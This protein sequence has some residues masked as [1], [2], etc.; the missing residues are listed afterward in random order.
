MLTEKVIRI[1]CIHLTLVVA[2]SCWLVSPVK[3]DTVDLAN[4][5][6]LITVDENCHGTINGFAGLN[7]LSCVFAPDPG[8]GGLPSVMTYNL[9]NP[10]GLVAGDVLLSDNGPILDVVRFNPGE[11]GG[12]LLLYSDNIDGFDSGADTIGP[13]GS[14]Y[15][16]HIVIPE[17]GTEAN[18]GAIYTPVVG[19]PG[20]VAGAAAPVTYDLISDGVGVVSTP[21]PSTLILLSAGLV[22]M[23]A[24][25]KKRKAYL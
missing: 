12:S 5:V 8:P 7:P 2:L 3:A 1:V 25:M 18:N 9:V 14:L 21:E 15:A 13:P 11:N 16:N 23:I 24:L 22:G 17:L 6:I 20:F 10:P 19:Q 4:G